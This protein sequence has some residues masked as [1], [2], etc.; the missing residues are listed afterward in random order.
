MVRIESVPFQRTSLG[1]QKK[2]NHQMENSPQLNISTISPNR[3]GICRKGTL[4]STAHASLRTSFIS[5]HNL[6]HRAIAKHFPTSPAG[7]GGGV[8]CTT[9][10]VCTKKEHKARRREGDKCFS[11]RF[12]LSVWL[13]CGG[14][15]FVQGQ[16]QLWPLVSDISHSA[17]Y[18]KPLESLRWGAL[19]PGDFFCHSG[20]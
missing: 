17:A 12:F 2:T 11:L 15:C 14:G 13:F 10:H 7:L 5:F 16:D 20:A 19:G 3:A 18:R 4:Y 6:A 9:A 1:S 8:S